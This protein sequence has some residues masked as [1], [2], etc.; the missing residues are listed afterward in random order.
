[1]ACPRCHVVVIGLVVVGHGRPVLV[2]KHA[3]HALEGQGG[4]RIYAQDAAL[5]DGR[6]DQARVGK[7][8]C[9]EL[10][11]V[12]RLAGDLRRAVYAGRGRAEIG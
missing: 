1:M 11:G 9:V 10:G 4:A 5:G 7:T 2:R 12:F 6:R 3:D 8:G